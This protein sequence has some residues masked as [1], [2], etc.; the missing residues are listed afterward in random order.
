MRGERDSAAVERISARVAQLTGLDPVAGAPACR[1][2]RHPHVRARAQ[3]RPRTRRQ[4]VRRDRD[5]DRS[6]S[7]ARRPRITTIR[8]SASSRAPLSSAMTDLYARVLNWRVEEPYQLLNGRVNSRW[9]WG[10][11]A[12]HAR[13]RRRSALGARG[14][15]AHA[16]A[17]HARRK[18][19][20]HALF[21]EPDDPRPDA[22]LRIARAA[23]ALG[24]WRRPHVL[25]ARCLAPRAARG[26]ASELYRAAGADAARARP[27]RSSYSAL[28]ASQSS[29]ALASASAASARDFDS[30]VA[31]AGSRANRSLASCA[32]IAAISA[33]SRPTAFS[34][35]SMRRLSGLSSSRFSAAARRWSVRE[36]LSR[37]SRCVARARLAPEH[38][39]AVIVEVAVEGLDRA[40]AD[41][42]EPVGAGLDQMPV[43]RDQDHGAGIVVDRLDQR[44]AAVDVEMVGR[45][46]E[47]EEMRPGE[48]REP[49]QQPR[50]LAAGETFRPACRPARRKSRCRRRARAPLPPARPASAGARA[51]RRFAPGPARRAGAA[52]NRRPRCARAA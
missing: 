15:S 22:G 11:G 32:S 24:L 16:R 33:V 41:Q 27:S 38:E 12:R 28:A 46:V 26:C 19:P 43:V 47:D 9:D 49:E 35:A 23:Q 25:L 10:G 51:R 39:A 20:R 31:L 3:S 44:G 37:S 50:L 7:D 17:G 52:R 13:D 18:R 4:H 48:G 30:A 6:R 2:R 40:V 1:P 5:R 14:R 45:L 34:A 42:P 21:R 36:T 8:C 29:S